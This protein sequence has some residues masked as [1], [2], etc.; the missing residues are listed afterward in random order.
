MYE[1]KPPHLLPNSLPLFCCVNCFKS[2]QRIALSDSRKKNAAWNLPE[3]AE[4]R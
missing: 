1:I 3:I 2:Q 4:R